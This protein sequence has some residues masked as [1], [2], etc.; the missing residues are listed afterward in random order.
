MHTANQRRLELNE[1]TKKFHPSAGPRLARLCSRRAAENCRVDQTQHQR[2]SVSAVAK[3]F[4]RGEN[5][6]GRAVK[7]VSES[8]GAG[9][10]GKI[11]EAAWLRAG[12][13]PCRQRLGRSAGAG[14][15]GF[16]GAESEIQSPKP[17]VA[18]A[19]FHAKLLALSGAGGY[20]RRG[21]KR[22]AAQAG[23]QFADRG[24]IA[25]WPAMEFQR[26]AHFCHHAKRAGR[27]RLFDGGAGKTLPR[28]K[29]R[30]RA[31]RGVCGFCQGE[32]AEAGTEIS[33]R[34]HRPD[35]FQGVFAVFSACR[36][37]CRPRRT[38]RG[39]G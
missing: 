6:G 10:A 11:G 12:K 31:G 33:A 27:T 22:G 9:I 14:G 16:C 3:S 2:K 1:S 15:A 4:T 18:S 29:G 20:S 21:K 7:A 8:D 26:R 36:L 39:A 19:I 5:G 23:F 35:F 30:R 13:H 32:R 34:P 24:G 25:A 37:F 38:H 17:K 28:A